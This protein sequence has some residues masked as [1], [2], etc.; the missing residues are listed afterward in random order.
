M[1]LPQHPNDGEVHPEP[2]SEPNSAQISERSSQ[3][4]P[5]LDIFHPGRKSPGPRTFPRQDS[6]HSPATRFD[7]KGMGLGLQQLWENRDRRHPRHA[8]VHRDARS[9]LPIPPTPRVAN[10][11]RRKPSYRASISGILR[12][13]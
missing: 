9:R 13:S 3:L 8:K 7:R 2:R 5:I 11:R 10:Q 4:N 6:I 1:W 12:V